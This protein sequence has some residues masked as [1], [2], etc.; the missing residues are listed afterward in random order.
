MKLAPDHDRAAR[1][2]GEFD[3]GPAVGQAAQRVDVRL[4]GARDRQADRLGAGRQQ[5]AV[6]GDLAAI[7][8]DH[9]AGT[10][11]DGGDVRLETKIDG[12][13][14]IEVVAAQRN[15]FLGRVAGEVI[16]GEVR[17]IDGCY[18]IIAQHDDAALVVLPPQHFR[19][20]E[21]G[22]AAAHDHD[23]LRHL[24]RGLARAVRASRR[25]A[26]P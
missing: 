23:L 8:E 13:V 3:D 2:L 19:S 22:S 6:V 1:R 11:I 18:V 14:G 25:Y 21:T 24:A 5:Q 17:P 10:R 16:L 26:F 20:G 4:V 15:P 12:V 7:G 9:L